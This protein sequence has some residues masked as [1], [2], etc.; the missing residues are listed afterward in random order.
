MSKI[1]FQNA[2]QF[3]QWLDCLQLYGFY[4]VKQR[5]PKRLADGTTKGHYYCTI[6][7][8][9]RPHRE[10][11][12]AQ[13]D[14]EFEIRTRKGT[15]CPAKFT[16]RASTDGTCV[17]EGSLDHNHGPRTGLPFPRLLRAEIDRLIHKGLTRKA[18]FDRLTAILR[19]RISRTQVLR[20]NSINVHVALR[21]T[22]RYIAGRFA[23]IE[24]AKWQQ[25]KDDTKSL[26]KLIRGE[27]QECV[28]FAKLIGEEFAGWDNNDLLIV[29][30]SPFMMEL[31]SKY[32]KHGCIVFMDG[33]HSTTR[34]QDVYLNTILV[35]HSST[36][37]FPV[38]SVDIFGILL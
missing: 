30:A 16:L 24:M 17:L 34:Y 37:G 27:Y 12:S 31:L 20:Q 5:A 35:R 26:S 25:D 8:K 14:Q 28:L 32:G 13:L 22:D 21:I 6:N 4:M 15:A 9:Y 36:R 2:L 3:E 11:G 33:T 7:G 29:V 1:S 23:E 38:R 18:I 19:D 10:E